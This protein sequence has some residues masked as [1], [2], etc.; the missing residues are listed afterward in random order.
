M[1]RKHAKTIRLTFSSLTVFLLTAMWTPAMAA[2]THDIPDDVN[3][4]FHTHAVATVKE[5][6]EGAVLLD[7]GEKELDYVDVSVG[8]PRQ[9]NVWT[10]E[11]RTGVPGAT[12]G[13]PIEQWAAPLFDQGKPVGSIQA[14]RNEEGVAGFAFFDQDRSLGEGLAQSQ[15]NGTVY[16]DAPLDAYFEFDGNVFQP[17]SNIAFVETPQALG[18]EKFQQQLTE[19]YQRD[20][21]AY[22]EAMKDGPRDDLAGGGAAIPTEHA[23]GWSTTHI[24]MLIVGAALVAVSIYVLVKRRSANS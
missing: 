7:T 2:T 20:A 3:E 1:M 16:Y 19:R 24:I 4:W 13:E 12:I 15:N 11:F 17:L 6:I 23:S 18:L 21:D 5:A 10:E 9:L 14:Y 22:A 8:E